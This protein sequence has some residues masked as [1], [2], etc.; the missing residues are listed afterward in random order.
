MID[1][2]KVKGVLKAIANLMAFGVFSITTCTAGF[3]LKGIDVS[4]ANG[5]IDWKKV[6][7]SGQVDFAIIRSGYGKE[8]YDIQTDSQYRRNLKEAKAVGIPIG[9]YHYSYAK[10]PYD[11]YLEAK[12]CLTLLKGNQYEYP[13]FFDIEDNQMANLGKEK[14]TNIARTFVNTI[15]S[16]GYY[17]GIYCNLYWANNKLD[18]DAL[19]DVDLWIAQYYNKCE[20]EG[21]YKMWQCSSKGRID[22][23]NANVD[24]NYAY[25]DYPRLMKTL[26][27]NGF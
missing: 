15:R 22:G 18:M 10:T 25:I 7:E 4:Y 17:A 19:S 20:Y 24:L 13:I 21:I 16:S 2:F 8:Y 23:I 11:A 6:K 5:V 14:L 1:V 26:H 27:K 3:A 12:F 9:V